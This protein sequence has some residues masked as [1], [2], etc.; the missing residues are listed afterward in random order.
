MPDGQ[1]PSRTV[2]VVDDLPEICAY[3]QS[4]LRR[5]RR[6]DLQS[7]TEI[8]SARALDLL[9]TR[10]FDLVI[11]DFRMREVDGLEVLAVAAAHGSGLRVLMTGYNELPATVERFQA[12]RI[13]AILQKPPRT[14]EVVE[15]LNGLL[16]F[17]EASL[18]S[19]R[20][21]A[22]EAER[23]LAIQPSPSVGEA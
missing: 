12:A 7:V 4:V 19:W 11:S 13:D 23:S 8:N 15:L 3:F 18:R 9:R 21:K 22:R 16:S 17:D 6:F 5:L 14:S 20:T 10:P 2:L 1:A